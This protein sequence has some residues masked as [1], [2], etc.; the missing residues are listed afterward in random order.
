MLL[1]TSLGR[2]G[3]ADAIEAAVDGSLRDGARTRDVA[4]G[5]PWLST[6]EFGAEVRRRLTDA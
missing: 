3:E 1:R 4:A 2:A 5:G 6:A